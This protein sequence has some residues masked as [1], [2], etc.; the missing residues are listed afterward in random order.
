MFGWN[1]SSK[2]E[3]YS[4]IYTYGHVGL[5]RIAVTQRDGSE[6]RTKTPIEGLGFSFAVS[7]IPKRLFTHAKRIN[8]GVK[9][10][11]KGWVLCKDGGTQDSLEVYFDLLPSKPIIKRLL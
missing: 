4:C 8:I 3:S 1:S 10:Y 9:T 11:F 7:E 6:S 5:W 2:N